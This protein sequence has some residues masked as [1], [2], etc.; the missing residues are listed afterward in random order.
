MKLQNI[1]YNT[2]PRY[3]THNQGRGRLYNVTVDAQKQYNV[4]TH[5]IHATG[6]NTDSTYLQKL[7]TRLISR[8][9]EWL[10]R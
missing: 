6:K 3:A 9:P 10:P 2:G 1:K 8:L 7:L 4:T 5:R